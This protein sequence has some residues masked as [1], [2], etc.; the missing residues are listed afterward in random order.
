MN[1]LGPR[2]V[3]GPNPPRSVAGSVAASVGEC[4]TWPDPRESNKSASAPRDGAILW[5]EVVN[6]WNG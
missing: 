1:L 6:A 4:S 5:Q 3:V 2:R